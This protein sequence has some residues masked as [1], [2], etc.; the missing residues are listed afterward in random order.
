MDFTS[1]IHHN[2]GLVHTL[3]LFI[4]FYTFFYV[5]KN[6][7]F[8]FPICVDRRTAQYKSVNNNSFYDALLH[9]CQN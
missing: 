9:W 1:T 7:N 5:V 6:N 8:E 2:I 4:A 3:N